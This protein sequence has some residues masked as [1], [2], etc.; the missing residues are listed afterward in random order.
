MKKTKLALLSILLVSITAC[1]VEEITPTPSLDNI[2][3][4]CCA[5][6]EDDPDGGSIPP[7]K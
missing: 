5:G 6:G 3:N 7:P 2:E 1:E 4:E